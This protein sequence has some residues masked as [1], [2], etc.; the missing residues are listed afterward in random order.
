MKSRTSKNSGQVVDN[1]EDTAR[2]KDVKPR[3]KRYSQDQ[4]FDSGVDSQTQATYST[5]ILQNHTVIAE[6]E[7][8]FIEV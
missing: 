7:Q 1:A 6:E 4:S 2:D 8:E 3:S 5:T